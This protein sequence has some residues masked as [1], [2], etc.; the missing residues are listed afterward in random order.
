AFAIVV[1]GATVSLASGGVSLT[2]GGVPPASGGVPPD[3]AGSNRATTP[4][5]PDIR[6]SHGPVPL[7]SPCQPAKTEPGAGWALSPTSE[8]RAC[9]CSQSP[10]QSMP[11]PV[12]SPL[13]APVIEAAR[14]RI[15]EF[16]IVVVAGS[17]V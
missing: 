1:S 15:P 2:S 9:H 7:Q 4:R 6:T 10:G 3:G 5:S 11:G 17:W 13:P 12:T 8:S 14:R 16:S